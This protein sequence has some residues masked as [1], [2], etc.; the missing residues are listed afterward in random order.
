MLN[1]EDYDYKTDVYSFGVVLYVMFT[2]SLPKKNLKDKTNGKIIN[3]PSSSNSISKICIDLIRK[4]MQPKPADRPSFDQILSY[5]RQN[6]Y[7][8]ADY[9]DH[10]IIY[11]R[12]H[13]L[14]LFEKYQ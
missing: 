12:D 1:E 8:L 9:V 6:D 13:E 5:I 3:L 14:E 10:S 7:K 11:K 4:C 2:G